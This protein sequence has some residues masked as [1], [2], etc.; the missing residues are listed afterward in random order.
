MLDGFGFLYR[1]IPDAAKACVLAGDLPTFEMSCVS[2]AR[3]AQTRAE[4]FSATTAWAGC[5]PGTR[6]VHNST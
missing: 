1:S 5:G 6:A 2:K 4:A 3:P